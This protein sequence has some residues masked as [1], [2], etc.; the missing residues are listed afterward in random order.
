MIVEKGVVAVGS[1]AGD[2]EWT[3]GPSFD[4]LD[5]GRL[6]DLVGTV[7][8]ASASDIETVVSIASRAQKSWAKTTLEERAAL[9]RRAASELEG[10]RE[11]LARLM[12]R[13][14]GSV[15][16]ISQNEVIMAAEALE[17]AAE[18]GVR[19]LSRNE[20]FA[21]DNSWVK[22]ESRPYGV[23]GCIV[24][25]N[26]PV[27]LT[28]QKVGPALIAGN[29]VIVKPSPYAPLAVSL[30]LRHFASFFP[31]GVINVIHGD[32]D[33]GAALISHPG[34]RKVSFTGGPETAKVIM[35]SAAETLTKVHFELGGNDPAIV[36][37]DTDLDV[38]VEK[39]VAGTYRRAG[40][41]CFAIKRVYVPKRLAADFNERLLARVAGITIGHG[42][43]QDAAMGPVNS[44]LQYDKLSALHGRLVASGAD[45]RMGGSKLSPGD[46][47]NGYYLQPSVVLGAQPDDEIVA[48]EQ[49]GPILPIV[50][51]E[52]EEEAVAMANGTE[53]GLGA[54][55]WSGDIERAVA[56]SSRIEA[57]MTFINGH[58]LTQLGRKQVPFGG[59]KQSGFGW[60]NS[61]HGI[62]EYVEF[63]STNVH[64]P[65][66]RQ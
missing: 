19:F 16:P 59:V 26:A 56:F 12:T 49:F 23:V 40:Q 10:S 15:L 38:T 20:S 64:Q 35:R 21:D 52:N 57:G 11:D 42:L 44:K 53:Y 66:G 31:P 1:L 55:V 28:V 51:Y 9:I 32:G 48:I 3:T 62:H 5:P 27:I 7:V 2:V 30:M 43:D 25:W 36:L 45:V 18:F 37:D 4:V 6:D 33:V 22:V 17:N 14:N 50:E 63:H 58:G 47:G 60:E 39:I 8:K 46:W 65:A 41:V 13:E 29:A 34:V 61:P 54:S 24:P